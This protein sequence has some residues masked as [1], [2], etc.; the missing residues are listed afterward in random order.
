MK[1]VYALRYLNPVLLAITLVAIP[2]KAALTANPSSLSFPLS[3]PPQGVDAFGP[4]S[5]FINTDNNVAAGISVTATTQSGGS[6]LTIQNPPS[7]TPAFLQVGVNRTGLAN[8]T[9]FGSVNVTALSGGH[10][11]ISI[12]VTLTV[13]G[14]SG[15][16]NYTLTPSTMSF[17]YVQGQSAPAAQQLTISSSTAFNY[18]ASAQSSS[19]WLAVSPT[20]GGP[21][22]FAALSVSI[23][24]PASLTANTYTGSILLN[25]GGQQATV[26][27]T[28]V[29]SPAGGGTG[30]FT[31][32]PTSLAFNYQIGSF[33][34]ASQTFTVN[35][36][37]QTQMNAQVTQGSAY[38]SV[39]PTLTPGATNSA[40]FTASVNTAALTSPGVYNGQIQVLGQNQA[41]VQVPVTVNVTTAGSGGTLSI[42]PSF[43]SFSS[44][45]VLAPQPQTLSVTSNTAGIASAAATVQSGSGWLTVTPQSANVGPGQP[46]ASFTVTANPFQSGVG[47]FNGS[48]VFTISGQQ[49]TVPVSF[50]VTSSGGG[51]SGL[52]VS[53]SQ[54]SLTSPQGPNV[55]AVSSSLTVTT[56][57]ASPITITITSNPA[58]IFTVVPQQTTTAPSAT[59]TVGA[60]PAGLN[61]GTYSGSFNVQSSAYGTVTVPMT[62]TVGPG[63]G[64][65]TTLGTTPSSL[66]FNFLPGGTAPSNQS[67]ELTTPTATAFTTIISGNIPG[68][69]IG[70]TSGSTVTSVSGQPAKA[71]IFVGVGPQNSPVGVYNGTITIN[72]VGYAA[73][74]VNVTLN[75]G[76][77]NAI[78]N[79]VS[80]SYQTGGLNPA[81][82]LITINS[83]TGT[84]TGFTALA[85][86]TSGGNW[87]Q[88]T[89]GSGTAPGV[90]GVSVNGQNMAQGTYTGTISVTLAGA[91]TPI[92]IPVTFTVSATPVLRVNL[93]STTFNYQIGS[94][95]PNQTQTIDIA[96]TGAALTFTA[97]TQIA[98]PAGGNWLSV[99]TSSST[100]PAFAQLNLNATGLAAGTYNGT[101]TFTATGQTPLVVPV[102]L[103]VSS[104]P[105]ISTGSI[106]LAFSG[107]AGTTPSSQTLLVATT[108]GALNVTPTVSVLTGGTGNWLS[109]TPSNTSLT[110]PQSLTVSVNPSGLPEGTYYGAV[111]LSTAP[112]TAANSPVVLPV[113]Y[114]V[115]SGG[116]GTGPG[117][118]TITPSVL[119]F[120]QIQGSLQTPAQTLNIATSGAALSYSLQVSTN[121]GGSWLQVNPATGA[122]PGSVQV[123]VNAGSLPLGAYSGNIIVTAPG[124]GNTPQVVPVNL[125][126]AT[127]PTVTATPASL[128]FSAVTTGATP[129][130]QSIDLRSTGANLNF[131]AAATVSTGTAQWLTVTPSSGLT[132]ATLTASVNTSLLQP[133]TYN[134]SIVINLGLA[135]PITIPVTLNYQ[136]LMA[137]AIAAVTSAASL[138]PTAVAPGQIVAIFGT[139]LGPTPG[140]NLR[141]TSSG[142]VDTSLSNVRVLFDGLPAPLTFVRTDVIIAVV[143]YA[144]A[145][146]AATN[147]QVEYQ[148]VRSTAINLRVVDTTPAIFTANQQGNGQAAIHLPDFSQ[149]GPNN[150]AVRGSYA[151]AYITGEGQTNPAGIDGLISSANLLRRPIGQ[152]Q[153]RVGGR[154]ATLIYAG[155]VPTTVLGLAQVSFFIPDDAPAGAAVPLE[156]VAGGVVTQ[157]GVTMAIR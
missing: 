51:G 88:I 127:A 138:L 100:T 139:N 147:L 133:G 151:T 130:S 36:A 98:T 120:V 141:L 55:P 75:I 65:T 74:T 33:A 111:L 135:Q 38:L 64:G 46:T 61:T 94:N 58:N 40:I 153:V 107:P 1:S 93:P 155:S 30:S 53:P 144:L 83:P 157:A 69:S 81:T 62:L 101:V 85:S 12:P 105:L 7:S 77:V 78:P 137:P 142:T 41:F 148:G 3:N 96:S 71:S 11:P 13:G 114:T 26:P 25:L 122:T 19:G 90:L 86:T 103:N 27:V 143:P 14:G 102:T 136:T 16:G 8:G 59:I 109:V 91:A 9:Y 5:L 68:L 152:V 134:G 124:A 70:P 89:P 54:I 37:T 123:T 48:I 116:G 39:T 115:G 154:N 4:Q 84:A 52:S 128:T 18:T 28:L 92:L 32:S 10:A 110:T 132:P 22:T 63:G 20:F 104:S 80:F 108:G 57:V 17:S 23:V 44:T 131:T 95:S 119:N 49:Q 15:T 2:G 56:P 118:L 149:N 146:R 66:F 60:S 34:P 6:W 87:L 29:V 156:I 35:S 79:Q 67:F 76:S 126:V 21:T 117:N 50:N 24:N 125:T 97:S 45:N 99:S 42:A 73:Q 140:V 112:G 150:P 145:G 113:V 47:T 82:Q 121:T 31:S 106:N 72:P 129:P 43:L